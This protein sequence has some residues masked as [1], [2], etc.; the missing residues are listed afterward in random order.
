MVL[1]LAVLS[2]NVALLTANLGGG[3]T[4]NDP[5]KTR[6]EADKG[7]ASLL[8]RMGPFEVSPSPARKSL[9]THRLDGVAALDATGVALVACNEGDRRKA[10]GH[11]R[12]G[13]QQEQES[14]RD[15]GEHRE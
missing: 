10:A 6:K 9:C 13:E 5:K 3:V 15:A 8:G 11:R 2:V 7:V 4:E 14:G 12:D 1:A